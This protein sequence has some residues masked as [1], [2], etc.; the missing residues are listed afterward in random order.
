M[1]CC[2]SKSDDNSRPPSN[3]GEVQ[4]T[5]KQQSYA[6]KTEEERIAMRDKIAEATERRIQAMEMRGISDKKA[7][8]IRTMKN[9]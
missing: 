6:A 2:G 5:K 8:R 9:S 7:E 1:G 3:R 4:Q